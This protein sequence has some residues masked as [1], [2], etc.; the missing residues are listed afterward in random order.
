M[1]VL[2]AALGSIFILTL[3]TLFRQGVG[4]SSHWWL[5]VPL[6]LILN[7]CV[8]R[9]VIGSPTYL[10]GIIL[11]PLL[12]GAGRIFL[13]QFILHEPI[14]KGSLLAAAA[15]LVGAAGGRFWR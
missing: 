1:Y 9:T 11:F 4:W 12:N 13:S 5:Y 14:A 10:S 8:Y 3:E 7:Y 6:S 15:L 2:W